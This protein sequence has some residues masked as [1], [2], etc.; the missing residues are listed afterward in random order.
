MNKIIVRLGEKTYPVF[1]G[2][3]LV[4]QAGMLLRRPLARRCRLA[5]VTDSNIGR[6]YGK[7]IRHSLERAGFSVNL[8]TLPPGEK[9]KSLKTVEKIY[10][11]LLSARLDRSSA[12]IGFGG[13]VI[14]DIAGFV[15]ST[16]MRGIDFIQV[17]SSLLAQVDSGV[18]GKVAINL[19]EGKNLIGSFYQPRLVI[20]DPSL[21]KTLPGREFLNGM[22]EVIKIALIR[23]PR[24]AGFLEKHRSEILSQEISPLAEM[25]KQTVE[26]KAGIVM[27][28][29]KEKNLRMILN[30]GHTIGH[31]I[32]HHGEYRHGEAIAL[33]MMCAARIASRM[34]LASLL[35]IRKQQDLL[36][37]YGLPVILKKSLKAPAI[38]KAL[39]FDKKMLLG[40]TRFVLLERLGKAIVVDGIKE[41]VIKS[42]IKEG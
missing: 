36:K 38:I 13:G 33:G 31:A 32:E 35:V 24:L 26:L 2:E 14:G 11:K 40:K 4:E 21:L 3:G 20:I 12:V 19:P 39:R 25:I 42:S 23:S 28:D 29:E 15:A 18:G 34:K 37:L 5:V 16:F 8:I 9:T 10:H 1:I 22:A 30:Y 6:L 27:K 17:P 41:D 7:K